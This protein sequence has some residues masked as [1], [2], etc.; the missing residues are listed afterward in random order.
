MATPAAPA[1]LDSFTPRTSIFNPTSTNRKLLRFSSMD[2]APPS[3][4]NQIS[5]PPQSE[6]RSRRASESEIGTVDL[7]VAET[8]FSNRFQELHPEAKP[9]DVKQ[10]N[11][12]KQNYQ[13]MQ[14]SNLYSKTHLTNHPLKMGEYNSNENAAGI[15]LEEIFTYID[16]PDETNPS[17]FKMDSSPVRQK[18]RHQTN[19]Q[20]RS[21]NNTMLK[22]IL[23]PSEG[24]AIHKGFN[25]MELNSSLHQGKEQSEHEVSSF[26]GNVED[27][28]ASQPKLWKDGKTMESPKRQSLTKNNEHL[29][30]ESPPSKNHRV[31]NIY[32]QNEKLA[33]SLEFS[34]MIQ[35]KEQSEIN[36]QDVSSFVGNEEDMN[37][38]RPKSWTKGK[39][40]KESPMGKVKS[41]R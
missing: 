1:K 40:M 25:S 34:S 20:A 4:K 18:K 15:S 38:S 39:T 29:S 17:Q 32:K 6:M 10:F 19:P 27:T 21:G 31:L 41:H 13:K 30:G 33:P 9:E 26:D 8:I 12:I 24:A 14:T 36:L 23:K 28:F 16:N 7:A 2:I 37:G 5:S 3:L 22:N 35:L 11:Q